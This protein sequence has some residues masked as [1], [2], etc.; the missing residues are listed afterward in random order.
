[1]HA[2]LGVETS[3]RH[4]RNVPS[5]LLTGSTPAPHDVHLRLAAVRWRHGWRP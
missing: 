5:I 4:R 3:L 1:M 2:D